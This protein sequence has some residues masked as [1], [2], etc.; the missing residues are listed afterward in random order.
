MLLISWSRISNSAKCGLRT[1]D[2]LQ[3]FDGIA[4]ASDGTVPFRAGER[5]SFS[6]LVSK[7][8][9]CEFAE[10]EIKRDGKPMKF[11]PDGK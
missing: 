7:K 5:I 2:V 3:K 1:G 9:G 11:S 8:F 4:V 6:H 10:I